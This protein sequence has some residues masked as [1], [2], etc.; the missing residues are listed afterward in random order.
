MITPSQRQ[1]LEAV[2]EALPEYK[3]KKTIEQIGRSYNYAYNQAL[4]D[5]RAIINEFLNEVESH[6]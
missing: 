1:I 5:V 4:D 3:G 6:D 2:L